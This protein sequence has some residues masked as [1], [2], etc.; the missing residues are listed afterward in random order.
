MVSDT[1]TIKVKVTAD[2]V[3]IDKYLAS[4]TGL[5]LSRSKVE[6]LITTGSVTVNGQPTAT[7]YQVQSG[8]NIT[9]TIPTPAP[10]ELM[11]EDID[12]EIVYEDDH[13]AVVNKPAGMV[14]HPAAGN[15]T[16]TLVNALLHR[17][18]TLAESSGM[19]RPGIVHRLDKSTSGLLVVAKTET[20]FAGLQK[21][22]QERRVAR[23]YWAI[24]CGHMKETEGTIDLPIGR[25]RSDRKKMSVTKT[26]SREA[27]T[28]YRVVERFRSYD[29]LEIT[30]GSG[31]THQIRVHF[32]HLGHPVLGDAEY[33]GRDS[34]HRGL[35]TPDRLLSKKIL[36]DL[37][38]QALHAI[39]LEFDH[40][41]TGK[42]ITFEAALPE[43]LVAAVERIRRQR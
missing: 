10:T 30:L 39:R 11:A 16:G 26:N 33:G 31:R 14:T 36:T 12:I 20:A 19:N 43:A 41:V 42:R 1:K 17:F 34:W 18:G 6:R 35:S 25:S 27:Q 13:L 2:G 4:V 37:T 28:H 32:S 3:R 9:I 22:I 38:R 23:T 24:I 5:G 29:L 15:R 40:P 21:A 8:D 7:K